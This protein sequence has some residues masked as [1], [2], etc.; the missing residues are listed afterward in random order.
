MFYVK[1]M[2]DHNHKS[3]FCSSRIATSVKPKSEKYNKKKE[4][5]IKKL[6]SNYS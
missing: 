5:I 1:K 4:V 2:V 6:M 3:C